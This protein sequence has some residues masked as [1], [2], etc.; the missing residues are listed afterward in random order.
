MRAMSASG[1]CAPIFTLKVRCRRASSLRS[2]SSTSCAGSPEASVQSTGMRSRTAP[3]SS[4]AA[5][6]P[7]V[8]PT[9]SNSAVSIAALAALLRLAAWSM[10]SAG[11]LEPVGALADD[12]GSEISVDIGLHGLDALLAPARAAERRRLADALRAVGEPQLAR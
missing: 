9:A 3:P 5:G 11:R 2:A 4:A 12:G 8:L 1:A 6:R 10:R 7:R